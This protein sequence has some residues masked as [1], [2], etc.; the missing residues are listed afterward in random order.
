V[1]AISPR[2]FT[3][4]NIQTFDLTA[5]TNGSAYE[6]RIGL[7]PSYGAGDRAYPLLVMLD[8]D[9]A[10]GTVYETMAL[11][12]MWSQAP[13]GEVIRQ[14]PEFIVVGI[15]LPDRAENPLRRNFE[16]MPD[17]EMSQLY[18]YPRRY[19]ER[20]TGLLGQPMRLGG[21]Q[22]FRSVLR[23]EILPVVEQHYRVS[24]DRRMLLGASAGGSFCCDT[25]FTQ[26]EL[27][28]DY[29]IVSPGIISPKIF[30]LEAAWAESHDDLNATVFLSAGQAEIGDSLHIVSNMARL[31]E[32]LHGRYYPGLRLDSMVF[33]DASHVDTVAPSL[34][35][36]LKKLLV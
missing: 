9:I 18:D 29:V 8:A 22:A 16:Y 28:T 32:Q 12:A 24:S 30:E 35:R 26:P 7:P 21:T 34:A 36:A 1:A 11:T 33:P 27:F 17:G 14:I 5:E 3:D 31:S 25:L 19:M 23:D 6:V 15:A 4:Q 20:V 10:F 2:V 13:V